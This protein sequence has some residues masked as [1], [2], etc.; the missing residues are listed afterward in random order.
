MEQGRAFLH[1]SCW[2][3]A[4]VWMVC[5]QRKSYDLDSFLGELWLR[6]LDLGSL[7]GKATGDSSIRLFNLHVLLCSD[8]NV[9]HLSNIVLHQMLVERVGDL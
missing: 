1:F 9:H 7:L 5:K 6:L 4:H 8:K 3:P 2:I